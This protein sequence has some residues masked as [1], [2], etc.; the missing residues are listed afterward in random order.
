MADTVNKVGT[1][2]PSSRPAG[3]LRFYEPHLHL[4]APF[5]SDWFGRKAEA[6]ARVFGTPTFLLVQSVIV[7]AWIA[8]NALGAALRWDPYPFILLNLTFSLQAAYA[9]PLILL[10]QTRQA[11]RDKALAMADA[12][13]RDAVARD[14]LQ[15]QEQAAEHAEQL[16]LLLESNTQLTAQSAVLGEHLEELMRE[17]HARVCAS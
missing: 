3:Y 4:A 6:F 14:N 5:G 2:R 10:A 8:L 1:H 15:R 17:I 7:A 11:D 13:H 16:R 12:E 9:A